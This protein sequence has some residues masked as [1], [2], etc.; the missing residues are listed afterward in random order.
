MQARRDSRPSRPGRGG[1]RRLSRA[2]PP[3]TGWHGRQDKAR[4]SPP[5]LWGR[6]RVG[7]RAGLSASPIAAKA[8][9]RP[10]SAQPPTPALPHKGGGSSAPHPRPRP[11]LSHPARRNAAQLGRP[12]AFPPPDIDRPAAFASK[13][14]PRP[15]PCTR[16]DASSRE[17]RP[18]GDSRRPPPRHPLRLRSAGR[19]GAAVDP[20]AA[21]AAL[22]HAGAE[23][24]AQG[25]AGRA[26]RQLAAGPARQ[27]AGALVFP[28][29]ARNS[30]SRST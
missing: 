1:D 23:L 21:G 18:L 17:R 25:H 2:R 26:F 27:L 7:G 9:T 12:A 29:P 13:S 20:A 5:P 14:W 4:K 15:A 19:A 16:V 6:V 30:R 28:E 11:R 24:F 22:P 10:R 3:P 8:G